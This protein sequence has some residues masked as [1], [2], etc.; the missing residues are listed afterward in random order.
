MLSTTR[1]IEFQSDIPTDEVFEN[2]QIYSL[3]GFP[4]FNKM[5]TAISD[6]SDKFS[7]LDAGLYILKCLGRDKNLHTWRLLVNESD[8]IVKVA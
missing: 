8:D 5:N 4:I 1:R 7:S 6:V 3:R 2:V